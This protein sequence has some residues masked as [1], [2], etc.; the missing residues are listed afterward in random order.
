[1]S[2]IISDQDK[3]VDSPEKTPTEYRGKVSPK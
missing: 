3:E 1:M 2:Y